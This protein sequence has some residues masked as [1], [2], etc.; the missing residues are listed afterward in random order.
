MEILSFPWGILVGTVV[1]QISAARE[2]LPGRLLLNG[3]MVCQVASVRSSCSLDL[4]RAPRVHEVVL[5]DAQGRERERVWLN[6]GPWRPRVSLKREPCDP[7]YLCFRVSGGHPE[8]KANS[9]HSSWGGR[10]T[11]EFRPKSG[12]EDSR[13]S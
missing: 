9:R 10:A 5:E 6:R 4:G 13:P 12:G 7:S 2:D 1:L 11:L 8:K 3:Q